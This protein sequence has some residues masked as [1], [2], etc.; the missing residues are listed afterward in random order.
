MDQSDSPIAHEM[1]SRRRIARP[2]VIVFALTLGVLVPLAGRALLQEASPTRNVPDLFNRMPDPS[3]QERMRPGQQGQ[4]DYERAVAL[5]QRQT[6]ADS[7]RIVKL[8]AQL[9]AE[10]DKT[11]D[12]KLSAGSMRKAEEIEKLAHH[13]KQSMT[14]NATPAVR[15]K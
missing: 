9:K 10:V 1:P 8:A 12:G 11:G 15:T 13:I 6:A 14:E 5:R 2:L 7:A 4:L 3:D